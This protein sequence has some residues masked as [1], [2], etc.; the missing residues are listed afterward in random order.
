MRYLYYKLIGGFVL[1]PKTTRLF[2]AYSSDGD[3][4]SKI[5][6]SLHG[7]AHCIPGCYPPGHSCIDV[8]HEYECSFPPAN[9]RE[10]LHAQLARQSRDKTHNELVVDLR[11][12]T[13]QLPDSI[14]AMFYLTTSSDEEIAR[15]RRTHADFLS[16]YPESNVKLLVLDLDGGKSGTDVFSPDDGRTSNGVGGKQNAPNVDWDNGAADDGW[17]LG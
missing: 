7:D 4:Q 12:V 6:P 16:T 2:C 15:M 13:P 11:S 9:L 5:C 10:A 14:E 1:N 8:G 17:V 3:S